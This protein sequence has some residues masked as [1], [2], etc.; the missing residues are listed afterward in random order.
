MG[1][2][3]S[4]LVSEELVLQDVPAGGCYRAGVLLSILVSEELVLQ[5]GNLVRTEYTSKNFQSS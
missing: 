4:I 3:L 1:D 5:E 2:Q